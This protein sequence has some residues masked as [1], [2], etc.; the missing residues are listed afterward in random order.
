MTKLMTGVSVAALALTVAACQSPVPQALETQD[1][2]AKFTSPIPNSPDVWPQKEWWHGFGSTELDGLIAEAEKNNLNIAIAFANVL[3]AEA[4]A[5][6]QRS[7]LF[8]TVTLQPSASRGQSLGGRISTGGGNTIAVPG[9]TANSFSL[10]A[11]GTWSPDIWGLAQDN[12]RAAVETL[13]A[14]R[15]AQEEVALTE[16]A[17]VATEYFTVLALRDEVTITKNNVDAAKRVLTVTRDR[18]KAGTDSELD[19][20]QEEATVEGQEAQLPVYEEQEHEAL[21]ALAIL[22]G[23]PPEGFDVTAQNLNGIKTPLV[24]PGLPSELL[25]RRP[26]IAEAEANLASAHANV[27]AARAAF[28]PVVSLTGSAGSSSSTI[29]TLFHASTFQWSLAASALETLFDAGK[30]FAQSDL[31]KAEQ[32]GLVATYRQTVISAFQNVET[33]LGQVTNYSAEEDALEREVKAAANAFRI[34]E[35]QYREGI[36]DITTVTTTEQTLFAAETSRA[37]AKLAHAQAVAGLYE[38]LGGGWS[39]NPADTTQTLPGTVPDAPKAPVPNP[40][41]S[42]WR[43]IVPNSAVDP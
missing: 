22:L 6:I 24:Q 34:S 37:Q 1:I 20:S 14:Q 4:Q 2:P 27:D 23:R 38:S 31:A 3:Q 8:P 41:D 40:Q 13:K 16:V 9:T 25:L 5:N 32:L 30:L 36:V 21:L 18:L 7:S 12:L 42:I 15:Y 35:L 10:T 28:F 43:H 19:L 11:N 26:D 33:E 29:G 39:E 17:D